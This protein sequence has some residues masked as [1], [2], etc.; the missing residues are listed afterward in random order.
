MN[1]VGSAL[2][3]GIACEPQRPP[4]V[5]HEVTR[6]QNQSDA[7]ATIA[8]QLEN[9]LAQVCRTLPATNA[10]NAPKSVPACAMANDLEAV[11]DRLLRV[12]ITLESVL[13]R[14]EI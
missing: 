7:L 13:D 1:R 4:A 2:G 12:T 8:E 10:S 11:A 3:Q 6:L 5:H 9:R 14:L